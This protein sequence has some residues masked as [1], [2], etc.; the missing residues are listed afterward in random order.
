MKRIPCVR[1]FLASLL[2]FPAMLV[3]AACQPSGGPQSGTTPPDTIETVD[4]GELETSEY[5]LVFPEAELA[6]YSGVTVSLCPPERLV[7][8]LPR[9][10]FDIPVQ[11]LISE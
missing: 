8:E 5:A 11:I 1:F 2:L 6:D 4:P 7:D 10:P 9:E 3:M